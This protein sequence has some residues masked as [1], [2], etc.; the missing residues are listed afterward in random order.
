VEGKI[1]FIL[2]MML[3]TYLVRLA[4]MLAISARNLPEPVVR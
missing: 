1:V 2:A 4:P 3:A